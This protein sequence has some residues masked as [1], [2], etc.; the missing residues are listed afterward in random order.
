MKNSQ[1]VKSYGATVLL[2]QWCHSCY[3]KENFVYMAIYKNQT[4]WQLPLEKEFN[5]IWV[6]LKY[7]HFARDLWFRVII[8]P[9]LVSFWIL[10]PTY[11]IKPFS[12]LLQTMY[13]TFCTNSVLRS[14]SI[15]L[16]QLCLWRMYWGKNNKHKNH[17]GI[18]VTH[19]KVFHE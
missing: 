6:Q 19:Y 14:V 8:T 12:L 7:W 16:S 17:L 10:C 11:R 4:C 15:F 3:C 5:A 2:F 9:T 1:L 13:E 18:P